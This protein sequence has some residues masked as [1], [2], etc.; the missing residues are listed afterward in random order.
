MRRRDSS[1]ASFEE[2]GIISEYAENGEPLCMAGMALDLSRLKW[3]EEKNRD[4]EL[5]FKK[6]LSGSDAKSIIEENRLLRVTIA[7]S[8]MVIGGFHQNYDTVLLQ[9]IQMIGESVGATFIGFWRNTEREE[10]MCCFLKYHWSTKAHVLDAEKNRTYFKYDNLFPA[11]KEKLAENHYLICNAKDISQGFLNVFDMT[12]AKSILLIPYYLHEGFWGMMGITRK[13]ETP[14]VPAEAEALQTG[15]KAIAFSISRNE[16]LGKINMDRDTA[17]AN[18]L[19]KGEFLSRMSHEMR[20]PLN[21]II[22]MTNIAIKEKDPQKAKE[23]LKKVEISSRLMLNV[24]NDVL[25][26]SKIEAG[27]LEIVKMPFDFAAMIK[28]AENI[29]RIKMEEKQQRFKVKCDN[30]I[31][32]MIISDEHRLLQ[33]IVN[34]LNNATKFT[35]DA[36]DISLTVIQKK[37]CETRV[38]LR[39]EVRDSGIGLALDQQKKLFHAFEQADGSITRKYGGTGL[40]LTICKKILNALDGDVWVKSKPDQ[41][42]CFFFEFEADIGISLAEANRQA[43][44]KPDSEKNE[45]IYNWKDYTILFAEDVEVNREIVEIT[46]GETEVRIVSVTNGKEAVEKFTANPEMY[47]LILMDV[48]MPVMDGLTATKQ[49]RAF[50]EELLEKQS[51]G[52]SEA[53]R[54]LCKQIPIIAMTANAFK[55]DVDICMA[56][57][58]NEHVAKPIALDEFFGVLEKHL[59]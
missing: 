14:F 49:I 4:L 17:M 39:V 3:A 25:D 36:G 34:L 56:A 16:I 18:T 59:K 46:L 6:I 48:Q 32:N 57:G 35:P 42:A 15:T 26:I 40:G 27:K 29:V 28:N 7:A 2:A 24:I 54:N 33:V 50:E 20:T 13:E 43:A 45:K 47:D 37:L 44:G 9:A 22:G 23:H 55:E 1:I 31:T 41:G 12:E 38:K 52:F 30:S 10:S 53:R 8:A 21:A 19:A 11:W 58:M 51:A 5:Q